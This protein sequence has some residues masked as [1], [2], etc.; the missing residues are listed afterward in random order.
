MFVV[1]ANFAM[2]DMVQPSKL[3]A[4]RFRNRYNV[5]HEWYGELPEARSADSV[6][7]H[8]R[9]PARSKS[10]PADDAFPPLAI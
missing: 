1:I 3:G 10:R 6:S 9:L 8:A 5:G 4:H 2:D 7:N